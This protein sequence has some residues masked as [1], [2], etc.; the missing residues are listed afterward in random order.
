MR[1]WIL[2]KLK[3]VEVLKEQLG[4][5]IKRYYKEELTEVTQYRPSS[6]KMVKAIFGPWIFR[7]TYTKDNFK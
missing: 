1:A 3:K 7:N 2:D 4:Q 5:S 6:I